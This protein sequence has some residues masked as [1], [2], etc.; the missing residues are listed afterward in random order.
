VAFY[1]PLLEYAHYLEAKLTA[2]DTNALIADYSYFREDKDLQLVQSTIRLSAHVLARDARQLAGQLTGRLLSN[3]SSSI[4]SLVKQAAA[5]KAWPWLR[6]LSPSL[7]APGG[8]LICTLEGHTG[9]VNAVAMTPDW[10]RAVSASWDYT[11]RLWDLESGQIHPPAQRPYGRGQRRGGDGRRP[12]GR[13]G[14]D[15][16][17]AATLGPGERPNH[18]PARSGSTKKRP[19]V[20]SRQNGRER[21]T[22]HSS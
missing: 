6:P 17:N 13:L 21:H 18:P 7:T 9:A 8:P 14:F 12:P 5:G 16:S 19:V 11:L 22:N 10:R 15:A 2:T 3:T 1:V 4:Q 20:N